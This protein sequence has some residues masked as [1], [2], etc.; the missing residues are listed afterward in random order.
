MVKLFERG[1][2]TMGKSNNRRGGGD[3]YSDYSDY[4]DY[5]DEPDD[6][7]FMNATDRGESTGSA[8]DM[9][10]DLTNDATATATRAQTK[11]NRT[12]QQAKRGNQTDR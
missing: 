5:D 6:L 7:G 12:R 11:Q 4:S 8:H 1:T 9:T 3:R 10:R 2:K